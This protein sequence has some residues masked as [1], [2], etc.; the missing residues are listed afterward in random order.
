MDSPDPV[1]TSW[2][3]KLTIETPEQ[4]HRWNFRWRARCR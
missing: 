1:I 4:T 2:D 3:D